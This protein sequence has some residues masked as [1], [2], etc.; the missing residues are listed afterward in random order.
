M[1]KNMKTVSL[2]FLFTLITSCSVMNIDSAIAD[3]NSKRHLVSLG[4]NKDDVLSLLMPGQMILDASTTK[5]PESYINSEG[6]TV[7]IYFL[8]SGRQPDDLTT[9]DE[10]TPYVFT[11]GVLTAV[12]WSSLGGPRSTG[13]VRQPAPQINNTTNVRVINQ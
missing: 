1:R 2:L 13:Q 6:Q 11:N 10:F 7:E 8:R 5:P 9:D 4:D 3:Y 12:G